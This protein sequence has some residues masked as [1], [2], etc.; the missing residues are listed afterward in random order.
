M[1]INVHRD[2]DT[3]DY[4]SRFINTSYKYINRGIVEV[5]YREDTEYIDWDVY[6]SG[7]LVKFLQEYVK[8]TN[9]DDSYRCFPPLDT[10]GKKL[11]LIASRNV[12]EYEIVEGTYI[13]GIQRVSPL[14]FCKC[15][16]TVPI[17]WQLETYCKDYF[18]LK[19]F[20]DIS[21]FIYNVC[22]LNRNSFTLNFR[23][24]I[25]DMTISEYMDS[26]L[27]HKYLGIM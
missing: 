22:Y 19:K 17:E 4:G 8:I 1:E 20:S 11:R 9:I 26:L 5:T 16:Y 25:L 18:N 14:Y 23:K 10:I 2:Y 7:V 15:D 3:L 21:D 24:Q 13:K 12:H 27:S 6:Q